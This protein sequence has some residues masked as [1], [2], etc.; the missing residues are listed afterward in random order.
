MIAFEAGAYA[1]FIVADDSAS[2]V[3]AF[4]DAWF[5]A[6]LEVGPDYSFDVKLEDLG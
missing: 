6:V 3:S 1:S 4:V 2:A 5:T